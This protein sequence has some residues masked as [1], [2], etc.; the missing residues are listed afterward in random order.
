MFERDDGESPMI[1]PQPPSGQSS[2]AWRLAGAGV[3]LAASVGG[4]CALGYWIDKKLDSSPW[5]L[6]IGAA[7]G[8][9]GGLYNLV[10]RSLHEMIRQQQP[11]KDQPPRGNGPAR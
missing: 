2:G 5:A 1:D 8:I 4:C 10:R 9:V 3:E 6:L 7:V 11:R